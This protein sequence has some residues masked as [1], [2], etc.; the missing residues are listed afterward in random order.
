MR[1]WRLRGVPKGAGF[2]R[3][4]QAQALHTDPQHR[5][6]FR[7]ET[8]GVEVEA[9]EDA[10]L[11]AFRDLLGLPFYPGPDPRTSCASSKQGTAL[12]FFCANA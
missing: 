3:G 11:G 9:L 10:C 8:V 1:A 12:R 4:K 6:E 2:A 7:V 5:A